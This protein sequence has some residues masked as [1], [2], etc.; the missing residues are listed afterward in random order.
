[1]DC[2]AELTSGGRAVVSD[3][4]TQALKRLV[5]DGKARGYVLYDEIERLLPAHYDGGS[6]LDDIFSELAGNNLEIRE[7][8]TNEPEGERNEKYESAWQEL[9]RITEAPA[10]EMYLREVKA[11]P[12]LTREE[13]VDFAKQIRE[14]GDVGESATKRLIEANLRLVVATVEHYCGRGCN[15]LDLLQDGN[16]GLMDAVHNFDHTRGFKFSPYAIWWIRRRLNDAAPAK[17]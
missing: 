9:Q 8:P 5:I 17:K 13:E 6:D 10:V 15:L 4:K 16:L 2:E 12:Y 3:D 1:M 7:V 14:G 11:M